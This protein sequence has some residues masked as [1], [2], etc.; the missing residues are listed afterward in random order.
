M[1]VF[2]VFVLRISKSARPVSGRCLRVEFALSL[3]LEGLPG[4]AV[5]AFF[6]RSAFGFKFLSGF[7]DDGE[8]IIFETMKLIPGDFSMFVSG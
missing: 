8:L 6:D 3:F 1:G 5:F 4:F 7:G 2:A